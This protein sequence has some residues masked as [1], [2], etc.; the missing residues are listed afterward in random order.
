MLIKSDLIE[1]DFN[2]VQ[3]FESQELDKL[4]NVKDS[5]KASKKYYHEPN[6]AVDPDKK[7]AYLAETKLDDL[8]RLHYIVRQ[9][10]VTTILEFGVGHSTRIFGDA[11]KKNSNE[12]SSRINDH[13]MIRR[14]NSFE[15]HSVDNYKVWIE[16]CKS[17]LKEELKLYLYFYFS[18]VSVSTFN[19]RVCT[20]YT[21]L[22]NVSPD[23]IYLDAPHQFYVEGD[24]R[25]LTTAHKDRMPMSADVLAFEHFLQPGTLICVDGRAANARFLKVNLQRSWAY[26]Y[27]EEWDQ[28]F[29]E[30]QEEPL[31]IYNKNLLDFCLGEPFYNRLKN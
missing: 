23:F 1:K 31:G 2:P 8:T 6:Y 21:K 15:C 20:Y 4:L 11:L 7:T 26:F 12:Y 10:K 18:N 3:Y 16:K 22:P 28:H 19:D 27:C 14:N 29:F 17:E 25:G 24:V 9:R 13:G 30:L 5:S